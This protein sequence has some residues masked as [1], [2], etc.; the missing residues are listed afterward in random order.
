MSQQR[1]FMSLTKNEARQLLKEHGLRI[2]APRLAVVCTLA[3]S[4]GPLSNS[5]VL[6]RLGETD[7]DPATIYRNLIKLR[8]AKIAKVVSR[9]GGIDRYELSRKNEGEHQHPHFHC[10]DCG[11]VKCLPVDLQVSL[12]S[13]GPWAAAIKAATVQ[14]RG[15][16]PDCADPPES[17][18]L[19]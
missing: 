14:L 16:C 19:A 9:A 8:D 2:T 1:E 6:G 13:E 7:W 11:E 18:A 17:A 5:E 15:E 4:H 3:E 10:D 12:P